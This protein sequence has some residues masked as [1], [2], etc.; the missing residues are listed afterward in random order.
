MYTP[1]LSSDGRVLQV[2]SLSL[3]AAHYVMR[4]ACTLAAYFFI[5]LL[6]QLL[7]LTVIKMV[8]M[9]RNIVE[10]RGIGNINSD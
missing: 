4:E 8:V 2:C 9:S 6:I 5:G 10:L 3:P 7:V 1:D